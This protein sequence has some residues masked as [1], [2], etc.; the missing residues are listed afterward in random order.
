MSSQPV[1]QSLMVGDLFPDVLRVSSEL[2]DF[3]S[4]QTEVR[5]TGDEE[6]R[7]APLAALYE[8]GSSPI[9]LF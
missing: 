9:H 1:G 7:S 8:Q 2:L 6:P 5:R 3:Y 4:S